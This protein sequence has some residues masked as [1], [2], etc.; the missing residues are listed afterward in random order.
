MHKEEVIRQAANWNVD[1]RC[2]LDMGCGNGIVTKLLLKHGAL[3]VD[4]SDPSDDA[5][6]RFTEKFGRPCLRYS[7]EDIAAG[8]FPKKTYSLVVCSYSLHFC[9]SSLVDFMCGLTKLTSTLLVIGPNGSPKIHS[10]YWR[11]DREQNVGS[12]AM[13]R[14]FRIKWIML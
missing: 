7:F 12:Y 4:S 11:L 9:K 6:L 10:K 13:G 2:V 14:L 3:E 5:Y 1:F 8:K